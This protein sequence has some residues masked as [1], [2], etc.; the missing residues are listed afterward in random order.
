MIEVGD[1]VQDNFGEKGIVLKINERTDTATVQVE[2]AGTHSYL[3]SD[4]TLLYK[5]D[6]FDENDFNDLVED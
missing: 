3:L 5:S 6:E 1:R 2:G 4:L